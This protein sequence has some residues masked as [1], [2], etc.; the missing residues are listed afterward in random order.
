MLAKPASLSPKLSPNSSPKS[1]LTSLN[2]QLLTSNGQPAACAVRLAAPVFPQFP[3]PNLSENLR[4]PQPVSPGP[5]DSLPR[6]LARASRLALIGG[7]NFDRPRPRS[8]LSGLS[9]GRRD[10]PE[11]REWAEIRTRVGRIIIFNQP[12]VPPPRHSAQPLDIQTGAILRQSTSYTV[13]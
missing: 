2:W 1:R 4:P 5:Q 6:I 8:Q 12:G 9:F 3:A 13:Q 7:R 11:R 10:A